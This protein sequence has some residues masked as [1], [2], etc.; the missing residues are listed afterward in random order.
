MTDTIDVA[1]TSS[2]AEGTHRQIRRYARF[3]ICDERELTALL[4]QTE[5]REPRQLRCKIIDLSLGGVKLSVSQEITLQD[6]VRISFELPEADVDLSVSATI[7]WVRKAGANTWRL[8]CAFEKELPESLIRQLAQHEYVDRRNCERSEHSLAISVKWES[9]Q[10]TIPAR[11]HDLSDGGFCMLCLDQPIEGD[12]FRMMLTTPD[13]ETIFVTARVQ[14]QKP[15]QDGFVAGCEFLEKDARREV[16]R[17]LTAANHSTEFD[18]ALSSSGQGDDPV[19]LDHLGFNALTIPEVAGEARTKL[20]VA[21]AAIGASFLL[22]ELSH[23]VGPIAWGAAFVAMLAA[24][25]WTGSYHGLT[26]RVLKKAA[27]AGNDGRQETID[28]VDDSNKDRI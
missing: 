13:G 14:W 15:M 24:A 26:G 27:R 18:E 17:A 4:E 2:L 5:G 19:V 23:S 21:T 9:T 16:Q 3:K 11:L 8:G 10:Q 12:R 1:G 6:A 20:I 7:C 22:L 28:G 25:I